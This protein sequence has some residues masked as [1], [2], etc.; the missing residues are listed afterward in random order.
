MNERFFYH[1]VH[2]IQKP[3][4]KRAANLIHNNILTFKNY[5]YNQQS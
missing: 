4:D 5:N 1:Y 2:V 3:F